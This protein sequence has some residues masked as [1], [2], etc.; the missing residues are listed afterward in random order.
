MAGS[1]TR[2][3]NGWPVAVLAVCC[4][5]GLTAAAAHATSDGEDLRPAGGDVPS[6][7]AD[8]A[9]R[10][11][12]RQV[13]V[14]A[15]QDEVDAALEAADSSSGIESLATQLRSLRDV[16]G[17]STARGP[18]LRVTLT[19]A[20]RSVDAPGIDPNYLVVHQQD[21]Q[22]FVNALWAGGAEAVSLQGQRL[23]STTAIVCVGSTVVIEGV[24]YAPP[25]VIEAVGDVAG[26]TYSLGTSPE[27]VNYE[28]YVKK[29]QLG[30]D[31]QS[32]DDLVLPPY[33]GATVLRYASAL[34]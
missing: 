34:D 4:V 31:V 18:G 5:A 12:D 29:Y 32:S 24:P 30:M 33:T 23:V 22:A 27:V 19:D 11:E 3:R 1:R 9:T 20:P 21:L 17:L 13:Q 16:A 14:R 6:L 8:R 28:R 10:V 7:V 2:R 15:L 25:Y 26:M